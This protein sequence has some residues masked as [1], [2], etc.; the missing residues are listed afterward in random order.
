MKLLSRFLAVVLSPLLAV[1]P[2][3]AQS[4]SVATPLDGGQVLQ[5]RVVGGDAVVPTAGSHPPAGIKVRVT[6]SSGAGVPNTAV[7]FRFPESGPSAKFADGTRVAVVHTDDAGLAHVEGIQ[8]DNVTASVGLRVTAAKN[9]GHAGLLVEQKLTQNTNAIAAPATPVIAPIPTTPISL[10]VAHADATNSRD[11]VPGRLQVASNSGPRF[12][13]VSTPRKKHP[14]METTETDG[15][16][17]SDERVSVARNS[18]AP[19]APADDS[20]DANVPVRHFASSGAS[21]L[22]EESPG[23]SVSSAGP[24]SHGHGKAKWLIAIGL[25]AGAG[26]AI[27]LTHK[28]GSGSSASGISIGAPSISVGHP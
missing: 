19:V 3:A 20:L 21:G 27:A 23:V 7:I 28:G 16:S 10:P 22:L 18:P 13:V 24:A 5:L 11:N 25:A 26:A 17:E 2:L 12:S 15:D 1:S 8:W 14:A 9:T 6:D 4:S